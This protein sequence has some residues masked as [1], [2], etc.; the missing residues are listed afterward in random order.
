MRRMAEETGGRVFRVDRRTSLQDIYKMIQD[1]MRSQYAAA[2]TP[3]NGN[4]DGTF[5]RTE[6][7]ARN[8]ELKVQVRRGYYAVKE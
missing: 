7:R 1:E 3:T 5:R 2:Y 8:K 6:V 4:K